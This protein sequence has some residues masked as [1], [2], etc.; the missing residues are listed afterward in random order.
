MLPLHLR[1]N[2]FFC[3]AK[4]LD[5]KVRVTDLLTIAVI[6]LEPTGFLMNFQTVL[7]STTVPLFC[8]R[9]DLMS[10][11]LCFTVNL[12]PLRFVYDPCILHGLR[13]KIKPTN[14]KTLRCVGSSRIVC[15]SILRP[16]SSVPAL[17]SNECR[18]NHVH[19]AARAGWSIGRL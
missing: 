2:L 15:A 6:S 3:S 16:W 12:A 13:L 1:T 8:T 5:L 14:E 7:R 11:P 19:P 10:T 4:L 17:K 9:S 18:R